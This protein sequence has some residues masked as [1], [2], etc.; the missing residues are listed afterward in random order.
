MKYDVWAKEYEQQLT[1]LKE[2]MADLKQQK[3]ECRIIKQTEALSERINSL[4]S[5]YLECKHT[6]AVLRERAEKE[7]SL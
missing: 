5:M 2:H 3:K 1:V 4:Y 7:K 6:A